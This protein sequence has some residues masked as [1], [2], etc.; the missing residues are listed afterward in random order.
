MILDL[1]YSPVYTKNRIK[2]SRHLGV[3][4][5]TF[6]QYILNWHMEGARQATGWRSEMNKCERRLA[7]WK[8]HTTNICVG[9]NFILSLQSTTAS[10]IVKQLEKIRIDFQGGG[11]LWKKYTSDKVA[12]E[13]TRKR[14][15]NLGVKNLN[16]QNKGLLFQWSWNFGYER[17]HP[18]KKI[19]LRKK[20]YARVGV[21]KG[22]GSPN[23]QL[24]TVEASSG[25]GQFHQLVQLMGD[26]RKTGIG[27][28]TGF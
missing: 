20:S 2:H 7:T 1:P 11:Q 24:V 5:K 16:L 10:N 6:L 27:D 21:W 17:V 4:L 23:Q 22:S 28:F 19:I 26:G 9:W 13:T 25:W 3:K 18:C 15:R 12:I 8:N 14:W